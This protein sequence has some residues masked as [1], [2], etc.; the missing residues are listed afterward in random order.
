MKY[1][2]KLSRHLDMITD[3]FGRGLS[4]LALAM[5]L[6]QG[7]VVFMRYVFGLSILW[8]QEGILYLHAIIFL[9]AAGYTL[10]HDGHVRVDIFYSGASPRTKA[11]IDIIGVVFLLTPVCVLL[12]WAGWPYVA[13]SWAVWEGSIEPSGIPAMFLLKTCILLFPATLLVQGFSLLLRSVLVLR[14][15]LATNAWQAPQIGT[16]G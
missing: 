11:I 10:L 16:K 8:M 9:S 4:W 6:L 1:M 14:G 2:L 12:L 3:T 13:S 7:A 5:V 15:V